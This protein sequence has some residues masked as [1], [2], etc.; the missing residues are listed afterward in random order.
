L[1]LL[2]RHNIKVRPISGLVCAFLGRPFSF[3]IEIST[4]KL[5]IS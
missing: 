1:A 2:D 4:N 5:K 3:P